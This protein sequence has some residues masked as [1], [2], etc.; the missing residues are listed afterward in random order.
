MLCLGAAVQAYF[1]YP[2]TCGKI[3]EEIE[4]MFSEGGPKPWHTKPGGSR[5]EAEIQAATARK[6]HGE[7]IYI[8]RPA[9]PHVAGEDIAEKGTGVNSMHV[10][11]K[12]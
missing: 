10:E 7:D 1:T 5:L 9:H 2:K 12:L 4:M 8:H 11:A 6:E 3:L